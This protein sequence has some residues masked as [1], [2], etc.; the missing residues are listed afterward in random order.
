MSAAEK[1]HPEMLFEGSPSVSPTAL[2]S[3]M[4]AAVALETFETFL[5]KAQEERNLGTEAQSRET[6]A[7]PK[8]A[9]NGVA[10]VEPKTIDEEARTVEVTWTTGAR[11]RR[12]G[13]FVEDFDEELSLDDTAVD[14]GRLNTGAPL[15]NSHA[16]TDLMSVVGVVERAWLQGPKGR[17]EGRAL[18]RF[19]DRSDVEPIWRDLRSGILRNI[20]VGYEVSKWEKVERKNDVP[21]MRASAWTPLELSLV[22]I[23]ADP[24]AQVRSAGESTLYPCVILTKGSEMADSAS[25][26]ADE[27]G[28]HLRAADEKPVEQPKQPEP[29]PDEP[30]PDETQE[31]TPVPVIPADAAIPQ[32]EG[33]HPVPNVDAGGEKKR[34]AATHSGL[35][36]VE[37]ERATQ[38]AIAAER[39]RAT[40]IMSRCAK[41]KLDASV[42]QKLVDDGVSLERALDM[43]IDARAA[44]QE[45]TE[46]RTLNPFG[47]GTGI[48]SHA[49]S[50]QI[51]NDEGGAKRAAMENA[52]LHRYNPA[53]F[54][55]TDH[56][57]Q[58]RGLG[59]PDMAREVVEENGIHTRGKSTAWIAETAI[60]PGLTRLGGLHTTSDFASVLSNVTNTTLRAGYDAA[61]RTFTP[62]A[63]RGTLPDYRAT[64]R[65]QMSTMPALLK[66]REH[67]EYERGT[68][69][70]GKETISLA[71]FGRV[72]GITREVI[73][74][75][76]LDAFTRIPEGFG[77]SASNLESDIV[78]SVLLANAAMNDGTALF[79]ANHANLGTGAALA[80][81]PLGAGYSAMMMQKGLDNATVLSI[82]PQYLLAPPVLISTVQ[83]L[84]ATLTPAQTSN[85][86]PDFI[87][88]LVPIIE[89]RLQ[90]GVTVDGTA[91]AGSNTAYFLIASPVTVDTVEYVYLEGEEG[92]YTETRNG[93]DVDG[94]EVKARLDFGAKA[95]DWRGMHKNAGV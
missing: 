88:N 29:Q 86:V 92:V 36:A 68:L 56:G 24:G 66:I 54:P 4:P 90:S 71:K 5:R 18:I 40:G 37:V 43:L 48:P 27:A 64:T 20:S 47:G 95:L 83:Q 89:P 15:L 65:V 30:K 84:L 3:G 76:N 26:P 21:L 57:R 31:G 51:L 46:V 22:P 32:V 75:D 17:R 49:G 41:L 8:L 39:A 10:R 25:R 87:R 38:R 61:P 6:A 59:L 13:F 94:V 50:A 78:Y 44:A 82:T 16:A 80:A 70:E 91:Y 85:V 23:P 1:V 9:R 14:L 63:R 77:A 74:N 42:G 62:W 34:S 73:I 81:T 93:F 53:R 58:Y 12:R 35:S 52:I 2:L 33:E 19:S 28:R 67:G 11:V 7:M 69:T 60:K 72:V 45:G 55:L 79:H